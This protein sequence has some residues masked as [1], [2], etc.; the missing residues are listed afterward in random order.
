MFCVLHTPY[1]GHFLQGKIFAKGSYIELGIKILTVL[2]SPSTQV[3]VTGVMVGAC[4]CICLASYF[5]ISPDT[6]CW[7][8]NYWPV[9]AD[10]W[11][12]SSSNYKYGPLSWWVLVLTSNITADGSP[13]NSGLGGLVVKYDGRT[14]CSRLEQ[15]YRDKTAQDETDCC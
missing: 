6:T 4:K 2:I 5:S 11:H 7:R 9:D 8:L 10:T 3:Q 1:S 14:I 15:S 13:D 12:W